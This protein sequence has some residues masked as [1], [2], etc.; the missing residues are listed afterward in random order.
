[1]LVDRYSG[2]HSISDSS[3]LAH[4]EEAVFNVAAHRPL[5]GEAL[6]RALNEQPNFIA[7]HA[8]KGFAGVMLARQESACAARGD[9]A[10]ARRAIKARRATG[11]EI[12][13]VEALGL[14]VAGR[15]LDA[16]ARLFML[17][18]VTSANVAGQVTIDAGTKSLAV[19]GPVPSLGQAGMG[20]RVSSVEVRVN[21]EPGGVRVAPP[22]K[23]DLTGLHEGRQ[24]LV[25]SPGPKVVDL[26]RQVQ[27]TPADSKIVEVNA[28]G[29]IKPPLLRSSEIVAIAV[30][31]VTQFRQAISGLP[32][33]NR[34]SAVA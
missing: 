3:A 34:W 27:F 18:T 30:T 29:L 1:M 9:F 22:W 4:F 19:N 24:L 21:G 33:P 32:E 13:L 15:L 11:S 6:G 10:S 23:F 14:A 28:N 12:A 16:A 2:H 8:L 31:L 20:D 25:S 5:A 26:T 7:A 17:T